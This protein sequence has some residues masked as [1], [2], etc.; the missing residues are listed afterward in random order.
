MIYLL[1]YTLLISTIIVYSLF[2][3]DILSPSVIVCGVFLFSTLCAMYNIK[4][5]AIDLQLKTYLIIS[6]GILIFVFFSY[7]ISRIYTKKILDENKKLISNKAS[8]RII[9]I[10]PIKFF[11]A[12]A[13]SIIFFL[14]YVKSV[15]ALANSFGASS[16]INNITSTYRMNVSYGDAS[17]PFVVNQMEKLMQC[18]AYIFLYIFINNIIMEGKFKKNILYIIPTLLFLIASLFAASRTDLLHFFIAAFAIYYMI[19]LRKYNWSRRINSKFI[20]NCFI[21]VILFFISFSLIRSLVG[22]LNETDPLSY[23]TTYA[24]GSIQLFDLYLKNPVTTTNIEEME[25]FTAF[26]NDL[27]KFGIGQEIILHQEFRGSNGIL[28]GN[29]YTGLRKY[30]QDFGIFGVIIFQCLLAI[31]FSIG[32]YRLKI[33]KDKQEFDLAIL[34]YVY[35]VPAIFMQSIQEQ[36]FSAY[37]SFN[38]IVIIF[39]MWLCYQFFI[40][41]KSNLNI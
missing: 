40:N 19:W 39:L 35:F 29:I 8:G 3:K 18:V 20:R 30:Y 2:D 34:I 33:I 26:H 11:L 7:F 4:T 22:R 9:N 15:Y 28:I 1:F 25:T 32:Y 36:F 12:I 16:D 5:W 24:G 38:S 6:F 17:L 27:T 23:I 37:V 13:F 10:E 21:G 14:I 31:I 41:E